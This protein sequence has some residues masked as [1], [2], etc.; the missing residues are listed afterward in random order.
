M[1][2]REL[3]V[4]LGGAAV[5]RPFA[6]HAQPRT[7]IPHIGYLW[8]GAD[9]EDGSTKR[10]LRQGLRDLGY[11]EGRDIIVD[12]RCADGHEERLA[13]LV[14]ELVDAKVDIIL[15]PGSV[16]TSAVKKATTA[17]QIVSTAAV[18]PHSK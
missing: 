17:I 14:G 16:V 4:L 11:V 5:A 1:K 18:R 8:L 2:R 12:Y 10:G 7:T 9:D 15:S 6:V 3:V 13:T